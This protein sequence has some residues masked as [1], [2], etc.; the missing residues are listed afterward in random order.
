MDF[1]AYTIGFRSWFKN[2]TDTNQG[3]ELI[4]KNSLLELETLYERVSGKSAL[5]IK[6]DGK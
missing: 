3:C 6:K 4:S 5:K 2:L 1:R